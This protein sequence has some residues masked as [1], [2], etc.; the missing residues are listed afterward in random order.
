MWSATTLLAALAALGILLPDGT[1][2]A[3]V[4]DERGERVLEQTLGEHHTYRH[5]DALAAQAQP[6]DA[7]ERFR[8]GERAS[9]EQPTTTQAAEEFGR[10]ERASQQQPTTADTLRPSTETQVGESWRHPGNVRARSAEPSGRPGW[11]VA[12]LGVLAGGLAV[13]TT[14][15]ARRRVRVGQAV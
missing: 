7:V 13:A 14:R 10:S 15:R 5:N 1:A 9:Q 12:G 2:L 3:T 11:L 6:T 4:A 8:Q